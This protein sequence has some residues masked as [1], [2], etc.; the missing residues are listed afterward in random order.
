MTDGTGS[1]GFLIG[2]GEMGREVAAFDW[3]ATSLGPITSWPAPLKTSVS[4]VLN[5]A[6]PAFVAWGPDL[7]T[8]HNDAFRS[9]L[10]SKPAPLGKPMRVVWSETWEQ[11][12]PFV[13]QTLSGKAV[14]IQNHEVEIDRSGTPELASFTFCYSPL[15]DENGV[16]QGMMDVVTETTLSVLAERKSRIRSGELVHRM[17]NTLAIVLAIANQTH[18]T[19]QTVKEANERLTRRLTTLGKAQSVL[20]GEDAAAGRIGDMIDSVLAPFR[21]G[22]GQLTVEGPNLHLTERHV[23]SLALALNELASN[24]TKYGALSVPTGRVRLTWHTTPTTFTLDWHE[25]G[26]PPVT[27]P[28]ASGFGTFLIRT[29]LADDF[30][31]DVAL[32]FPTEGVVFRLSTALPNLAVRRGPAHDAA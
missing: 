31:G 32:D 27:P 18:R 14:Y 8:I 6:F 29:M 17:K 19:S 30:D 24:A 2:G 7:V 5:L 23:F 28:Q 3:S 11:V 20:I 10:G 4:N 16:V 9:I 22:S 13:A 25:T 15:R 1:L 26:G 12:E 21:Q